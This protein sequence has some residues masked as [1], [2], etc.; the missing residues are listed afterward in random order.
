[1]YQCLCEEASTF[2]ALLE[3]L[4]R[5]TAILEEEDDGCAYVVA[6]GKEK[7]ACPD[8]TGLTISQLHHL[9]R[10]QHQPRVVAGQILQMKEPL[11]CILHTLWASL[12]QGGVRDY[13]YRN[14]FSHLL[15]E[16]ILNLLIRD[17]PV[18]QRTVG[19]MTGSLHARPDQVEKDLQAAENML[20]QLQGLAKRTEQV[21]QIWS[22]IWESPCQDWLVREAA[23]DDRHS[24]LILNLL[25]QS[26]R[27]IPDN[28]KYHKHELD[29]VGDMTRAT[30]SCNPGFTAD[31]LHS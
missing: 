25:G 13:R 29:T 27:M 24:Q 14:W 8:G 28:S 11:H 18:S 30:W 10:D 4:Q 22:W 19:L 12:G 21:N 7:K 3:P 20:S 5:R 26:S 6:A 2:A 16:L 15:H 9:R 23:D 31:N 1:M 17:Q